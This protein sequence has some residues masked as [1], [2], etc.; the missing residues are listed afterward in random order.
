MLPVPDADLAGALPD[1][2]HGFYENGAATL[3]QTRHFIGALQRVGRGED[4]DRLLTAMLERLADGSAFG[5]CSTGVDWRMWDGTRCGY[6]GLLTDQFG[7][8]VVPPGV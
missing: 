1:L 5:G 4:A 6:E 7:V 3:S 2:H 8:L